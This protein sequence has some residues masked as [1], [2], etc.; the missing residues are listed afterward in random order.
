MNCLKKIFGF[1]VF[2]SLF[3][4]FFYRLS[5][6]PMVIFAFYCINL[7]LVSR[8]D[9]IFLTFIEGCSTTLFRVLHRK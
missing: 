8:V 2:G 9:L 1:K 3:L 5:N 6:S 4:V 7:F